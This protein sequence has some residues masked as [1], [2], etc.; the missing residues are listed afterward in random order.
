MSEL[1]VERARRGDLAAFQEVYRDHVGRVYA[2]AIRMSADPARAEDLTQEVFVKAWRKLGSYRGT[3]AFSTWLHRLA[4]NTI[5]D[6]LKKKRPVELPPVERAWM[7]ATTP[8]FELERAIAGLPEVARRV[9]VL[10]DVEGFTHVEIGE[11]LGTTP[12]TARSNLHRAR[13]LLREALS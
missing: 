3:A 4:V 13:Q 10:H 6:G 1:A 12:G 9:F 7:P 5:L 8:A 11:L 2:L